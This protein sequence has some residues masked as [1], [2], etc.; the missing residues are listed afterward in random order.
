MEMLVVVCVN[1]G[2]DSIRSVGIPFTS[3]TVE[4]PVVSAMVVMIAILRFKNLGGVGRGKVW[5]ARTIIVRKQLE[6]FQIPE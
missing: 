2:F 4:G 3:R 1:C 5:D 6:A